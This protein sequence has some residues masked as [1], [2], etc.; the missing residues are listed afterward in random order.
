[1]KNIVKKISI[2]ILACYSISNFAQNGCSTA[3]PFCTGTTYSNSMVNNNTSSGIGSN[4]GCILHA[5]QAYHFFAQAQNSGSVTIQVNGTSDVDL[6]SWDGIVGYQNLCTITSQSNP[7]ACSSSS[8]TSESITFN[9]IAGQFYLITATSPTS[10]SV[11]F[12]LNQI[13]GNGF[14]CVNSCAQTIATPTICYVTANSNSNNEIYFNHYSNPFKK[15]TIIYR[16]N[17]MNL[18]DS[19]GYVLS[20]QPDKF[21]DLTSNSSQQSYKYSL[22]Y[23]DSCNFTTNLSPSH[24]TILLQSSLGTGSQINLTWNQYLGLP[25]TSYYIYRGSSPSNM[26]FINQVSGSTFAYTDLTP[27][28]GLNYYRIGFAKPTNCTSSAMSTDS[29]IASNFRT[30]QFVGVVENNTSINVMVYPNPTNSMLHIVFENKQAHEIKTTITNA[31][32]ELLLFSENQNEID[33]SNLSNGIYYLT[34]NIKDQ[35]IKQKIIVQK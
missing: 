7:L 19:I 34:I 4:Y 10:V 22:A 12:T 6:I 32:G 31:L 23:L 26:Q 3:M 18:W 9:I 5:P 27:P 29:I 1:M 33:L 16:E 24:K 11:Q 2:I 13:S 17:S 14:L 8:A 35:I 30:N 21:I 20:S 15:G 25:I 28:T